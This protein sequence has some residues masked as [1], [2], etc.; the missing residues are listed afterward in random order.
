MGRS[1]NRSSCSWFGFKLLS[2]REQERI[3]SSEAPRQKQDRKQ[4]AIWGN[5]LKQP[6]SSNIESLHGEESIRIVEGEQV[7]PTRS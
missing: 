3:Q 7:V 6:H 1:G 4:N 5:L 2:N